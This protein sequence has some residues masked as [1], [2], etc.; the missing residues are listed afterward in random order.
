[1]SFNEQ[2]IKTIANLARLKFPKEDEERF[3][4]DIDSILA[5]VEQLKEVDVTDVEPLISVSPR[6]SDTAIREDVVTEGN[7]Q[8]ELMANAPESVQGFYEVPRMVE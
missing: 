7:V 3:M 1:M 8:A 6:E 2:T 4:K 5:W